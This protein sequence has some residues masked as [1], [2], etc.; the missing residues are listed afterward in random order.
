MRDWH[1]KNDGIGFACIII[2][3]Y[4]VFYIER[5]SPEGH[6]SLNGRLVSLMEGEDEI[7]PE[8]SAIT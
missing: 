6:S 7:F 4:Q 1:V 8:K 3:L 2:N 5:E